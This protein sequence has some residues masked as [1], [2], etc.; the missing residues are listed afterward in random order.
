MILTGLVA[1]TVLMILVAGGVGGAI[2]HLQ[3]RKADEL[4]PKSS[5]YYFLLSI[6][7]AFSVPL[8]L[9]L[10]KSELL[11]DVL[12][13]D[14]SKAQDWFILFAMCLVAAIY[15]QNFLETVSK[16][17][18]Q[19]VQ[20]AVDTSQKAAQTANKALEQSLNADTDPAAKTNFTKAVAASVTLSG[21]ADPNRQK[22]LDALKNPK[23]RLGRRTIAGIA[24]ET[25]LSSAAISTILD[26][27]IAEG[28]VAKESGESSDTDYYVLC[29]PTE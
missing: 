23:Y 25:N 12:T 9:S 28:I 16:N 24:A 22:I 26:K 7:A 18:L 15:A 29:A 14:Q 20:A 2:N 13:L 4:I 17:L 5:V 1:G 10:T 3:A 11:Q 21:H 27:L 6:A 8:F 19:R